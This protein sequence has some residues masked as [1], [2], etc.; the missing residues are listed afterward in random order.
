MK[1]GN[2]DDDPVFVEYNDENLEHVNAGPDYGQPN[3]SSAWQETDSIEYPA[4]VSEIQEKIFSR[5]FKFSSK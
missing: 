5:R 1:H 3:S 4:Y 2:S